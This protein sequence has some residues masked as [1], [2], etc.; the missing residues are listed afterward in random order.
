M[1]T[2]R[3]GPNKRIRTI[4]TCDGCEQLSLLAEKKIAAIGTGYDT[5]YIPHCSQPFDPSRGWGWISK[6]E[7]E[8]VLEEKMILTPKWCPYRSEEKEG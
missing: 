1:S 2:H 3:K 6:L 5:K 7:E 8:C 4:Y